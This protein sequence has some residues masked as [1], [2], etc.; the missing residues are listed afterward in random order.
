MWEAPPWTSGA[1]SRAHPDHPLRTHP[2]VIATAHNVAHSEELYA[3]LPGAAVE[4]VTRALRGQEPLY[5]RNPAVIPRW[6]ER[7]ARLADR[8]SAEPGP[9]IRLRI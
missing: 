2:R 7:L 3:R 1:R 8:H 5:V 6:R 9:D 4:N